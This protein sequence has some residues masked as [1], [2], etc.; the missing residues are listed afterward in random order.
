MNNFFVLVFRIYL[1]HQKKVISI[2]VKKFS[3][4]RGIDCDT[5]FI[6]L[7]KYFDNF[8]RQKKKVKWVLHKKKYFSVTLNTSW[9]IRVREYYYDYQNKMCVRKFKK[10]FKKME[11]KLRK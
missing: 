10:Y 4:T 8:N 7:K 11:K 1:S 6:T 5:K 3:Q 2:E 9:L